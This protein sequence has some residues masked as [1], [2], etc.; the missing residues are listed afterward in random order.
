MYKQWLQNIDNL[1]E[2]LVGKD[3]LEFTYTERSHHCITLNEVDFKVFYH[4]SLW[5]EHYSPANGTVSYI[6]KLQDM[7]STDMDIKA[8]EE[9]VTKTMEPKWYR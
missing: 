2:C 8:P 9:N 3:Q 4:H 5:E 6:K 7:S 1:L